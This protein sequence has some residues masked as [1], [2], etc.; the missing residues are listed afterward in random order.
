M[1]KSEGKN[2]RLLRLKLGTSILTLKQ[3]ASTT[4]SRSKKVAVNL[5]L[6]ATRDNIP[7]PQSWNLM[8]TTFSSKL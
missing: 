4:W 2:L 7:S 8:C 3:W 1:F 5:G 6:S